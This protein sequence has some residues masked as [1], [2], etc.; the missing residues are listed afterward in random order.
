LLATRKKLDKLLAVRYLRQAASRHSVNN[1]NLQTR[2]CQ[3][4][5]HCCQ[6][7]RFWP[8]LGQWTSTNKRTNEL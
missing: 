7:A 2:T 8:T 5:G 4:P 6:C 1:N 3:T